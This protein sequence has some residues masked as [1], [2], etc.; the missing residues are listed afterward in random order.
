MGILG[1]TITGMGSHERE[2]KRESVCVCV[3]ERIR[4]EGGGSLLLAVQGVQNP[5]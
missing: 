3:F 1:H 4:C 2:R 5:F